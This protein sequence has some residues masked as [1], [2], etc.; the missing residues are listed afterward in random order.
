MEQQ[1]KLSS[2]IRT[3]VSAEAFGKYH[4]KEE[5]KPVSIPKAETTKAK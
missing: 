2:G 1:K 5:F 4:K 3:S